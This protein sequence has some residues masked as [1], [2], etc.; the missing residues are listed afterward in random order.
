MSSQSLQCTL[1]S[2]LYS[3]IFKH[4]TLRITMQS[5]YDTVPCCV[6]DAQAC[7]VLELQLEPQGSVGDI[8]NGVSLCEAKITRTTVLLE[9]ITA[10]YQTEV[11]LAYMIDPFGPNAGRVFIPLYRTFRFM[12]MRPIAV[13]LLSFPPE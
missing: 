4:K 2:L 13:R 8:M 9:E 1:Y 10:P 5:R 12:I 6:H 11:T 7:N 3:G